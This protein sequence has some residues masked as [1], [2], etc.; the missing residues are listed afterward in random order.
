[1][2]LSVKIIRLLYAGIVRRFGKIEKTVLTGQTKATRNVGAVRHAR[3]INDVVETVDSQ[4]STRV[5]CVS[6]FVIVEI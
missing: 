6:S 5:A 4:N 2:V 3:A 1:M